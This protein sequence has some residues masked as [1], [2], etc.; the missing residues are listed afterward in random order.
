M[1]VPVVEIVADSLHRL[2][3]VRTL[4]QSRDGKRSVASGDGILVAKPR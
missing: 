4:A 1:V 3:V 2:W